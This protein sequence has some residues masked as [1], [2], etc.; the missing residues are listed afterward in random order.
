M[1]CSASFCKAL[2]CRFLGASPKSNSLPDARCRLPQLVALAL[3]VCKLL[4]ADL[5]QLHACQSCPGSS[6]SRATHHCRPC[7]WALF[8]TKEVQE[9]DPCKALSAQERNAYRFPSVGL[10]CLLSISIANPKDVS[11][12]EDSGAAL[13]SMNQT[14]LAKQS[15][16]L[17]QQLCR[18]PHS[19]K[20]RKASFTAASPTLSSFLRSS[21]VTVGR[22]RDINNQRV[23]ILVAW[24][25]DALR[26]G[27]I[28]PLGFSF[29]E[30]LVFD[31]WAWSCKSILSWVKLSGIV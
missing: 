1:S 17:R 21:I 22:R 15:A 9:S 29:I 23:S 6:S 7:V 3:A 20:R 27:N 12:Q 26:C 19:R 13:P 16:I 10:S 31:R 11:L 18:A 25:I 5:M 28:E 30:D 24:R 14:S 4:L 8:G 2:P